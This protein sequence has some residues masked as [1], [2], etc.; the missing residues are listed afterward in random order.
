MGRGFFLTFE[1][2]DGSGKTTQINKLKSWLESQ[3][4]Q[5]I[6][7]R[8]PGATVIGERIRQLLLAS[9]TQNLAPRAELGLM[10][11]DRAQAIA[12]VIF[13]ALEA[14]QVVLCDRYTDSTE[15]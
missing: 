12:E 13:P 15:A 8:Q 2:L 4:H 7:T 1:G 14:G 5:V 11:S 3:G 6:V 10:F 9:R